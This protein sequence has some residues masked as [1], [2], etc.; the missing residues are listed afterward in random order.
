MLLLRLLLSRGYCSSTPAAVLLVRLQAIV[1]DVADNTKRCQDQTQAQEH[2][3]GGHAEA[4]LG[5]AHLVSMIS[6][7]GAADR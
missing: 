6:K 7:A 4:C 5:I 3:D 1:R 2:E